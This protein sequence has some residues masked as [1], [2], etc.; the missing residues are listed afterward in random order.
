MTCDEVAE[1]VDLSRTIKGK[2]CSQ[3]GDLVAFGARKQQLRGNSLQRPQ[4]KT[5][6][7]PQKN[8][9]SCSEQAAKGKTVSRSTALQRPYRIL[10]YWD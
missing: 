6:K 2:P 5:A 1:L 9:K 8:D 10:G 7:L 4:R 3:M